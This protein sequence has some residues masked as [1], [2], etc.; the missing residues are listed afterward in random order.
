MA[1]LL[2]RALL[3]RL[4]LE[5]GHLCAAVRSTQGLLAGATIELPYE[6]RS[7]GYLPD[8]AGLQACY[9]CCV[10]LPCEQGLVLP[11]VLATLVH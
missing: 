3:V 8:W 9:P 1:S 4:V 6:Q 5:P 10:T 11:A 2:C 7:K